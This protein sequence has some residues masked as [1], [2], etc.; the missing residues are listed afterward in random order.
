MPT[1]L[2]NFKAATR[3]QMKTIYELIHLSVSL[4]QDAFLSGLRITL[5]SIPPLLLGLMMKRLDVTG[6]AFLGGLYA[7]LAD[8]GGIYRQRALSMGLATICMAL[9]A[10]IATLVGGIFWLAIP[11]MFLWAF[12]FS[13][14]SAYG[15]LGAKVNF[16]VI[17]IFI[18]TLGQP[19]HLLMASERCLAFL[20]GGAWAM[21]LSLAFW[22]F[23][24]YQPVR[25]SV[26]DYYRSLSSFM[27]QAYD[28]V[29]RLD[30]QQRWS[31]LVTSERALVMAAHDQAHKV[32]VQSRVQQESSS[33]IEQHLLMLTFNADRLFEETI[34]LVESIEAVTRQT[35]LADMR[36]LLADTVQKIAKELLHLAKSIDQDILLDRASL[37]E[38]YTSIETSQ[39][40][41][42]MHLA[43]LMHHP[44]ALSKVRATIV[45]LG[46]LNNSLK[47]IAASV[48]QAHPSTVPQVNTK[49]AKQWREA[50]L[51]LKN[52]LT[53]RSLVFRHALRLATVTTISVAIYLFF[54]LHNG[55]WIPLTALFILKPEFGGTHQRSIQRISGT[56]FGG[57]LGGAIAL[58]VHNELLLVACLIVLG[59]M[60][61]AHLKGNYGIFVFFLTPFV[62]IMLD[63]SMPG[64][65]QIAVIRIF[66][67]FIGGLLAFLTGYLFWPLWE[68][69]RLPEQLIRTIAANRAF[70]RGVLQSYQ[71]TAL[72]PDNVQRTSHEAYRENANA[73]AAFQRLLGEPLNQRGNVE[74]FYALVT[75]NQQFCD[76]ITTLATHIR[77]LD[78]KPSTRDVEEWMRRID[79]MLLSI[80]RSIRSGSYLH[81]HSQLEEKLQD[82]QIS[83][84][85]LIEVPCSAALH[86][87]A[88][89]PAIAHQKI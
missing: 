26:A 61:F 17:G 30:T 59:F 4:N 79:T 77:S 88:A 27:Q 46:H 43:R 42:R 10:F 67:T 6:M 68:R 47:T 74:L 19:A 18:I 1:I 7:C 12:C 34:A 15:N 52:N 20:T 29:T 2:S 37:Q 41:L 72:A 71:A 66:N 86:W 5:I 62:V 32:V 54:H 8:V 36:N 45:S 48:Q 87:E 39:D 49:Q 64:N 50:F 14:L 23:R 78:G 40:N 69:E 73:A 81:Q 3:Q 53:A 85:Q 44:S 31:E 76:S 33:S 55:F 57:M 22:P 82:I 63:L 58:T 89:F 56:A 60:A 75:Y 11:L 16:V 51:T 35:N 84:Q 65:W 24:P 9:A 83:L 80:E 25:R 21:L 28:V 13:M 38:T 70:L